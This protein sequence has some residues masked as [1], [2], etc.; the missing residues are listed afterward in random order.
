M[1]DYHTLEY[2]RLTEEE[3]GESGSEQL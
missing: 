3:L 2:E 1:Q